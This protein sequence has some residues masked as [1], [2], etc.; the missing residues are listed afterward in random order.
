METL[1]GFHSQ[2]LVAQSSKMENARTLKGTS[3]NIKCYV[4][5]LGFNSYICY[6]NTYDC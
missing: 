6:I 2:I 5:L 1:A 4:L 3:V